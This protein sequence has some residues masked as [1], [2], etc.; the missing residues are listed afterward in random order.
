[1]PHRSSRGISRLLRRARR[2]LSLR[3][4][5]PGFFFRLL[6]LVVVPLDGKEHA[7][8]ENGHL[9]DNEDYRDPIHL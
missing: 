2:E 6:P 5:S 8:A 7:G 3:P 9:E 1:M 4:Q